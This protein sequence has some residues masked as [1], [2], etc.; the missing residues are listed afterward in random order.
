MT[1]WIPKLLCLLRIIARLSEGCHPTLPR[2]C[3][4]WLTPTALGA[5]FLSCKKSA[6]S[7]PMN[8]CKLLHIKGSCAY[9]LTP[10]KKI[11]LVIYLQLLLAHREASS[12]VIMR[13]CWF[14]SSCHMAYIHIF[15][16]R[17]LILQLHTLFNR[18]LV[19]YNSKRF[20][21]INNALKLHIGISRSPTKIKAPPSKSLLFG[22][23]STF[24]F[25][26]RCTHN[27]DLMHHSLLMHNTGIY[28][29]IFLRFRLMIKKTDAL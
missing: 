29:I 9:P 21:H 25:L 19:Y 1:S 8:F 17:S 26:L 16:L 13:F 18:L 2:V 15:K 11:I 12:T 27:A 20:L 6:H 7:R 24:H 4:I 23:K 14:L 10:A 5:P 28:D 22:V 3:L